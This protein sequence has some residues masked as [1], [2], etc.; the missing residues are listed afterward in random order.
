MSMP[1]RGIRIIELSQA[2]AGPFAMRTLADLGAEV[3]KVEAPTGGDMSRRIGPPFLNGE[4]AYFMNVN[5]NKTGITVDLRKA[6]GQEVLY[7]LVRIS[8]VVFDA[9]RPTALSRMGLDF[10][11]LKRINPSIIDC[12][13]SGFG[14]EGPYR[15]RPA[16]DGI[17]QAMGGGM[18]V[19]GKEGWPPVSMGFPVGDLVGG[20]VAA[21]GIAT[22][23]VG[24]QR[25][26]EARRVDVSLLDV[27][28]AL[29]GHLGQNY[30]VTGEVPKPIG[31]S[32]PTNQPVGAY[33]AGDGSYLQVHCPADQFAQNLFRLIAS[34][35]DGMGWLASDPRFADR[36][37]RVANRDALD[38]VL[39]EAFR[40]KPRDEWVSLFQEWD[41]PGGPVNTIEEALNDPQV[42][43]RDM[44]TEIDH[45]VAGPYKTAG[46]PIKTGS[47]E[48]FSPSPT[49]GQHTDAV[50][51]GLLGYT[52]TEIESLREAGAV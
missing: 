18:S 36:D 50:L 29:Q 21:L 42:R 13:L 40:S 38:D 14:Q 43:L 1:L 49:L 34:Q 30:L 17:V 26:D 16:F 22:A 27:Q 48:S 31:S 6:E 52:T 2:L 23:L 5:R 20:Y 32:H 3:I 51:G 44:V 24:R 47:H 28:I 25:G 12:S 45:P 39:G 9:F 10:E 15:E 7:R 11:I 4:S 37:A 33:Q 35:V 8:D 46:N 19:T 41:V